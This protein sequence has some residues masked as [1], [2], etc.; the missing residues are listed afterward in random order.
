MGVV[1]KLCE[2]VKEVFDRFLCKYCGKEKPWEDRDYDM[3]LYLAK[4]ASFEA[5]G[6]MEG[7][8]PYLICKQCSEEAKSKEN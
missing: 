7:I 6:H 3:G 4:I 5:L 1:C 8:T 2:G